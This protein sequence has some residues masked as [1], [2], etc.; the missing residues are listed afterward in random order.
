[1]QI[2]ELSTT[3]SKKKRIGRGGKRGTYSGRG[4]KGQKSRSG[5]NVDPLFEGGRT[6]LIQKMKK[7]R[8]FKSPH[9]K[10]TV[11]SLAGID[12][13]FSDGDTISIATLLEKSLVSHKKKRDGARIV[14]NGEISKKVTIASEIGVSTKAKEMIE[15]AGGKIEGVN[16]VEEKR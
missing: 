16:T 14:A 1:M 5:G 13:V 7:K 15:K 12:K 4:M 8:G 2:H 10:K 6:S 11:I 9:A 3:T